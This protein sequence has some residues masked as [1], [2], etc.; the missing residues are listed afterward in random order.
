MSPYKVMVDDN[1]HFTDDSPEFAHD[2]NV[3]VVHGFASLWR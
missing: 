2:K 3:D 1:Y